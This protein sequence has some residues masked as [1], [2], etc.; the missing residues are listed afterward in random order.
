MEQDFDRIDKIG[1]EHDLDKIW[2]GLVRIGQYLDRTRT[3]IGQDLDKT[4]QDLNNILRGF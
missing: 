4:E 3:R 1:L 2:K